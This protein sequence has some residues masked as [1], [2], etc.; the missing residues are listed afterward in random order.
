MKSETLQK[1]M[2]G[3]AAALAALLFANLCYG[4]QHPDAMAAAAGVFK[5][6]ASAAPSPYASASASPDAE[7]E[8]PLASAAAE[9]NAKFKGSA[10]ESPQSPVPSASASASPSAPVEPAAS[11]STSLAA[12]ASPASTA[13]TERSIM[14]ATLAPIGEDLPEC[15]LK[16]SSTDVSG[17]GD[18]VVDVTVNDGASVSVIPTE[19]IKYWYQPGYLYLYPYESGSVRV[20]AYKEGYKSVSKTVSV[21]YAP[22]TPSP[23]PSATPAAAN[24]DTSSETASSGSSSSNS[25]SS[26]DSSY[27]LLSDENLL[28]PTLTRNDDLSFWFKNHMDGT[29][30]YF[31]DYAAQYG[32]DPYLAISIAVHETGYGSSDYCNRLN[33]FGGMFGGDGQAKQYDTAQEGVEALIRLLSW[34]KGQGRTTVASIGEL[35]CP[36]SDAWVSRIITIYNSFH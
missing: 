34:Y 13:K 18:L 4:V 30:D 6:S 3:A 22:P 1:I 10:K 23:T 24:T 31:F 15:T 2:A 27:S 5:V 9:A 36:G 28:T 21:T 33:N 17:A 29:K 7:T 35:Y 20:T 26:S 14:T 8:D 32:V 16:V 19:G 12:A 11:S 25:T